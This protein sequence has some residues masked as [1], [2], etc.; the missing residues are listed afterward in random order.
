MRIPSPPKQDLAPRAWPQRCSTTN[1]SVVLAARGADD[2]ARAARGELYQRYF[3]PVYAFIASRRTR[4]VA[5]QLTQAFFVERLL[6]NNDLEGFDPDKCRTFRGRLFTA[7]NSFLKN[8][9]RW[10]FRKRRDARRT[11][12]LD[13]EAAEIRFLREPS[14]DP[15]QLFSRAWA[16][17]TLATAISRTRSAYCAAARK[18]RAVAESRFD[19]LKRFLPG[20]EL[21]ETAYRDTA[22]ELGMSAEAVKQAV[23]QL[24]RLFAEQLRAHVSELVASEDD[25]DAEIRFLR[26]AVAVHPGGD[27]SPLQ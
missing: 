20:P 2:L 9:R 1:L 3:Y 16:L 23:H 21:E 11:L 6:C 25:V 18:Q 26:E 7:V 12:A 27:K 4:A 15:E 19:H 10:E 13:F 8:R 22:A 5:E 14:A 17:C 24:R